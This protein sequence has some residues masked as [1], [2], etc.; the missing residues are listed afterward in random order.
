MSLL[1]CHRNDD[2]LTISLSA[3][4][5]RFRYRDTY[6]TCIDLMRAGLVNVRPLITHRHSFTEREVLAG[7]SRAHE[8]T[9]GCIKV[10]FNLSGEEDEGDVAPTSSDV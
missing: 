3:T 7:F 2:H 8:G 9:D 4:I 5:S 6:P 1:R 10:M